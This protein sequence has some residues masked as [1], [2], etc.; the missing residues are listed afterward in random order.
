MTPHSTAIDRV[1][2]PVLLD[3]ALQ[4]ATGWA[5]LAVVEAGLA[6]HGELRGSDADR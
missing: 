5:R 2:R 6:P 1:R 3:S 4:L